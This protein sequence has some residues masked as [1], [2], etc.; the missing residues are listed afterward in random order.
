[1]TKRCSDFASPE[2]IRIPACRR[3]LNATAANRPISAY[4]CWYSAG[5]SPAFPSGC[6]ASLARRPCALSE[7]APVNAN[8]TGSIANNRCRIV[9]HT[10]SG[11]RGKDEDATGTKSAHE[12]LR[13]NREP[14][15]CSP[16]R[17]H[18]CTIGSVTVEFPAPQPSCVE[19]GAR[20][21][22]PRSDID[23]FEPANHPSS[24]KT[25]PICP[26]R[27]LRRAKRNAFA[28]AEGTMVAVFTHNSPNG[29]TEEP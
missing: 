7:G 25:K 19:K 12:H 20:L 10:P 3:R 24:S 18:S 8:T 29:R 27:A 13:K 11:P 16:F 5:F 22:L 14:G 26:K 9:S 23:R 17:K 2:P 6:L 4:G 15:S 28:K 1:M 21:Y